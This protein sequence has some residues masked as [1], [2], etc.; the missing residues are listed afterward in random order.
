MEYLKNS[1]EKIISDSFD[2]SVPVIIQK[3]AN[4]KFGDYTTNVAMIIAS[5]LK[6][7]VKDVA[8]IIANSLET[9]KVIKKI[10]IA[11]AGFINI[12]LSA[13]FTLN[14]IIE[15]L[16]KKEEYGNSNI[17]KDKNINLEF[18]SANPTGPVHIA[19][20]RWAA[21]GSSLANLLIFCG[22]SVT[23]EYYFNDFGNQIDKFAMSLYNFANNISDSKSEYTGE[24]IEQIVKNVGKN[25][26]I[27]EYKQKGTQIMFNEIKNS[28]KNFRTHFDVFFHEQDLQK[29]NAVNSVIEI[30][31]K[32]NNV[33]K[34]DGAL[35]LK[36]TK[37]GDDKDRVI[38][39]ANGESTYF[40]SDIAYILNKHKRKFTKAIY[41]L[42]ADHHGYINRLKSS[43][44]ALGYKSD[45][46]EVLIGQMVSL[47][48]DKKKVRMSKR[49]GNI[50]TLDD[51]VDSIGVD[52]ARYALVR[53]SINSAM[54]IDL[55]LWSKKS[56]DNPVY[57]VQYAYARTKH[58]SKRVNFEYIDNIDE[59]LFVKHFTD[60]QTKEL[61]VNLSEFKNIIK[62]CANTR[63]VHKLPHY[64][65]NLA[66]SYH[67]WYGK[68][69]VIPN[70][71]EK[72]TDVHKLR[73]MINDSCSIVLKNC[74]TL[75]NVSAPEQM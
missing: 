4:I 73:L 32:T 21:V 19:G 40:A 56:A 67:K 60:L 47:V 54:N 53:T 12:Y 68:N 29:E 39:K 70:M 61:L 57:Y 66:A 51:L 59:S 43:A 3:P 74:L 38:V 1:I 22:A 65:E 41:I 5:K 69:K 23:N 17:Y 75:L 58:I 45:F 34:K 26:S 36:T 7:N 2:I 52:A 16:N 42:G 72:I 31:T 49:A 20:A 55:D 10:E 24:Y 30:L 14:S 8:M 28:L 64:L 46:I 62:T 6:M 33:Y 13:T 35:F 11:G 25:L 9:E 71:N 15:I 63:E 44:L 18:V 27:N 37:Y 48:K 50:I